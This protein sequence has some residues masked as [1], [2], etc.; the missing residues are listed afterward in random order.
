MAYD[1]S[2]FPLSLRLLP[3]I[4]SIKDKPSDMGL[5]DI[6]DKD[7][8]IKAKGVIDSHLCH[9]PFCPSPTSKALVTM[10]DNVIASAWW[11]ELLYFFIKPLVCGCL[12]KSPG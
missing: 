4:T 1:K 2:T 8:W 11:E 10:P 12:L 9:A 3:P 6:M 5:K 7:S